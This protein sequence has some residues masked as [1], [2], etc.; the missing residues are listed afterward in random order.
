MFVCLYEY[1]Y[2]YIHTHKHVH[3]YIQRI[4]LNDNGG[5]KCVLDFRHIHVYLC[6]CMCIYIHTCTY[7]H[8]YIHT[9][10]QR[11]LLNDDGGFKRLLE[12]MATTLTSTKNKHMKSTAGVCAE[13]VG[14]VHLCVCV[15]VD[16]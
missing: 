1:I 9:Y 3:T 16:L 6:V 4:L 8:T 7:I 2:I 14:Q 5:F 10:I 15:C 12:I 13:V 11:I